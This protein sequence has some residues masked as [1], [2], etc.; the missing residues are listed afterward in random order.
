MEKMYDINV[1]MRPTLSDEELKAVTQKV[2]NQIET[3]KGEITEVKEPEKKRAP[4]EIKKSRDAYYYYLKVKAD[5][6]SIK[7]VSERLRLTEEVV[8]FM[9]SEAVAMKDSKKKIK[10]ASKPKKTPAAPAVPAFSEA[11]EAAEAPAKPAG[12]GEAAQ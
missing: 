12:T 5:S 2:K 1:F 10:K 11:P 4:Y 6:L 8:R 3:I 9:I 7:D